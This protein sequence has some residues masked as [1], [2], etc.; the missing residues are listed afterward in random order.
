MSDVILE[1]LDFNDEG[2]MTDP[3]QWNEDIARELARQEGIVELTEDHW[4][5]IRFCR[6]ST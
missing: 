4:E 5:I 2:F 6:A 3:E 1:K